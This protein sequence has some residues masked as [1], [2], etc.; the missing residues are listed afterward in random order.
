MPLEYRAQVLW[1]RW[2]L[3]LLVRVR[4]EPCRVYQELARWVPW[5]P[6]S[7]GCRVSVARQQVLARWVQWV[8]WELVYREFRVLVRW[9][10]WE[11]VCPE[12]RVL[13]RWV[14]APREFPADRWDS[15]D[16][17]EELL[18]LPNQ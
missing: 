13:D 16:F 15:A 10:R 18:L 1:V 5:E 12:F 3:G 6:V 8:R 9:D 17:R 14:R 2:E 7:L 11:L 4:W